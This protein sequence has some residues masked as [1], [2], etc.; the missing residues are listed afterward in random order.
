MQ[1]KERTLPYPALTPWGNDVAPYDFKSNAALRFDNAWFYLDYKCTTSNHKLSGMVDS[2]LANLGVHVEC[3]SNFFRKLYQYNSMEG[4]AEIP[5][6]AVR[7]V[8]EVCFF[9]CA[10]SEITSYRPEG[11]HPDYGNME[12]DLPKGA[13]LAIGDSFRFNAESRYDD[14]KNLASIFSI[15]K[16]ETLSGNMVAHSFDGDRIHAYLSPALHKKYGQIKESPHMPVLLSTTLFVPI[17]TTAVHWLRENEVDLDEYRWTRVLKKKAEAVSIDLLDPAKECFE[18][19]QLLF[20][21]P[22]GRTLQEL[23]LLAKEVE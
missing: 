10:P 8:L 1:V 9:I 17:L 21:A 5:A 18:I 19:A 12:F 23:D 4:T 15:I 3:K 6:E 7:G 2:G 11:L 20:D 14:I 16:D 22:Y 13:L